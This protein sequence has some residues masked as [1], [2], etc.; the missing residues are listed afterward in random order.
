MEVGEG[1][2]E[3]E[4]DAQPP[5]VA[6]VVT[7]DPGPWFEATLAGLDGQDYEGLSVLVLDAGSRED[8]TPR[9]AAIAPNAFVRR[10]PTDPGYGQALNEVLSMVQGA[11]YLLFCHD[12]AAAAPDA[13]RL[14]VEEAYRSNAGVVGAKLVDWD[15]HDVLSSVGLAIDKTGVVA[16]LADPG[17]LDQEQHDAVRDVFAVDGAFMLVRGDLFSTLGGFEPAL[18]PH[19]EDIDLCWRA[20]V[21]G[22][23]VL[24][25]PGARVAHVAAAVNGMRG[26][27]G[28]AQ[29]SEPDPDRVRDQIRPLQVRHRIRMVLTN[30]KPFHLLRVL[31][32]MVTVQVIELVYALLA[33]RPRVA[34]AL[35][36]GWRANLKDLSNISAARSRLDAIRQFPDAEVRRLQSRGFARVNAFLSGQ[37]RGEDRARSLAASSAGLMREFA[38]S[39][40]AIAGWTTLL[41]VLV[42][43][44]RGLLS[45]HL[46]DIG[47]FAQPPGAGALLRQFGGGWRVTGLGSESAAPPAFAVL[48]ALGALL[49]GRVALVQHVL[50]VLMLPIGL[51]GA[52]RL[53]RTT[54]VARAGLLGAAAYALVPLPYAAFARGRFDG[55]VAYAVVPWT[56]AA[57]RGAA[58]G[59][60]ARAG[61]PA[62][63]RDRRPFF[64]WWRRGLPV[65]VLVSLGAMFAPALLPA[66]LLM[67]VSVL[68][69]SA[70]MRTTDAGGRAIT[71]AVVTVGVALLLTAPWSFDL[72]NPA[73]RGAGFFGPGLAEW[74]GMSLGAALRMET[75]ALG[76]APWGWALLVAA[77]LP[78]VIGRGWRLTWAVRCWAIVVVHAV[79]IWAAGR[80]WLGIPVPSP[81]VLLAPVGAALAWSVAL[82]LV[83]FRVDLPDYRFG[84]RQLASVAAAVGFACAA[85]P[86]V[87]AATNG[88]WGLSQRSFG[89]ELAYLPEQA[90][91]GD[92]RVLWVGDP[93]A[94]PLG[95]WRL[96]DGLAFGTSRNG[97]PDF[98]AQLAPAVAGPSQVIADAVDVALAQRTTR[99]GHLLAPM[100]IRYVVVPQRLGPRAAQRPALEP[101]ADIPGALAEQVDLRQLEGG[102]D[103]VVYENAAWAPARVLLDDAQAV[104]VTGTDLASAGSAEL[105]GAKPA[106][107]RRTGQFRYEGSVPRDST[108]YFAEAASPRWSL[109]AGGE[110]AARRPALGWASTYSTSPGGKATLSYSTS[111]LRWVGLVLQLAVWIVV[112]RA[113]LNDRR[114]R[115][116]RVS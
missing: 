68:V 51:L 5:V 21:A 3:Y 59:L 32:Q 114:L 80:G 86:V 39:R 55:L 16:P 108:V 64:G 116:Q 113:A 17:E 66:I 49:G 85:L 13:V 2:A 110:T 9:V 82:G 79:A 12:D 37:L 40:I 109:R 93:E 111:P 81:D 28:S 96:R 25:A 102:A 106:L 27:D 101:V 112:V 24:V 107:E 73:S 72:L 77:A 46:P 8:V 43:G 98:T 18:A 30:Y 105:A 48:G 23:R 44:T 38:G 74:R 19:G 89:D 10:L 29:I 103:A 95:G 62:D 14:L 42:V 22:A 91:D 94:L 83:A 34:A 92:F 65:A 53:A 35:V 58:D 84:I 31:P 20:Q 1:P 67:G 57:L 104:A 76:D 100:A 70:L 87:G 63:G 78:L 47:Q 50:V 99:L 4:L 33:G 7:R 69:G 52:Y 15:R 45:G 61:E 88:R 75:G 41:V 115:R 71:L 6:V 26:G 90:R 60:G 11:A 56:L 36:G 54:A 97:V